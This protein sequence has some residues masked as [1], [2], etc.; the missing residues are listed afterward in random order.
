MGRNI[1]ELDD[2]EG[3]LK[4]LKYIVDSLVIEFGEN[5]IVKFDAGYNNV[6]VIID[7]HE[8]TSRNKL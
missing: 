2:F 8:N 7:N 5:S 1:E 6:N 4:Q 3:S